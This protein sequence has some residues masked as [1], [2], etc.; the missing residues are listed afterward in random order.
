M[1]PAQFLTQHNPD[2]GIALVRRNTSAGML[3]ARDDIPTL[4]HL[5]VMYG[6]ST[7]IAWIKILLDSIDSVLGMKSFSEQARS[8]A[9]RLIYAKYKNM[10]V[11][12]IL[13]F[14]ALY[15]LGE[16]AE[17]TEHIG[18]IQKVMTALRYYCIRAND[19]ATALIRA[20][21]LQKEH[22]ERCRRGI[23][24]ISYDEYRKEQGNV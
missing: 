12:N 22:D 1:T 20:Q 19:A 13:H 18:G 8:D 23:N 11:G 16:F 15:K 17:K 2:V 4:E 24:A 14:A 21:E 6:I 9:A 3:A 7:P 5:A 10:N